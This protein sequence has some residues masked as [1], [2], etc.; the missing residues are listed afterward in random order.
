VNIIA[1]FWFSGFPSPSFGSPGSLIEYI[2]FV[3]E[4]HRTQD[5]GIKLYLLYNNEKKKALVKAF[6]HLIFSVYIGFDKF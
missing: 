1:W 3:Q 2:S 5:L 4:K 6:S